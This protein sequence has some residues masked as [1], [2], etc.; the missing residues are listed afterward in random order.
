MRYSYRGFAIVTKVRVATDGQADGGQ[1]IYQVVRL[2][3]G[4]YEVH[5][6]GVNWPHHVFVSKSFKV[7]GAD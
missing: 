1:L 3:D 7:L 6:I 4:E 5:T 2:S